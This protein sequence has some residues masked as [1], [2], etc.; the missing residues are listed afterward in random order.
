LIALRLGLP[1]LF[2]LALPHC[3]RLPLILPG[4]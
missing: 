4:L 2:V 1:A 3:A